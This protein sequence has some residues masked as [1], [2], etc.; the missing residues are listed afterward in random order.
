MAGRS[1]VRMREICR[2]GNNYDPRAG[3]PVVR[4]H[5]YG[6]ITNIMVLSIPEP[7]CAEGPKYPRVFDNSILKLEGDRQ[8]LFVR[9]RDQLF[10]A[11]FGR[12][13]AGKSV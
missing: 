8:Q 4:R 5:N 3:R 1:H 12:R 6:T 13:I 11:R 7:A 10:Y 2:R 9:L